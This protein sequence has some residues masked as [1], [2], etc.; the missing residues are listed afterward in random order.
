[1]TEDEK[2]EILCEVKKDID[3]S[4]NAQ[5]LTLQ[6]G[7][8]KKLDEF[9]GLQQQLRDFRSKDKEQVDVIADITSKVKDMV[10]MNKKVDEMHAVFVKSNWAIRTTVKIF[11]A[12]GVTFGGIIAI[13][14]L[15]KK[16][17]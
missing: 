7:I 6:Q 2:L 9:A 16:I 15:I 4:V 14:E 8:S 1:M 17:K 13:I 5:I 12:I 10:E 3:S 11:G